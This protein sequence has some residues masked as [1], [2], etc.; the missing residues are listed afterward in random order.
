MNLIPW[1]DIPDILID[2]NYLTL[3]GSIVPDINTSFDFNM[4]FIRKFDVSNNDTNKISIF[5]SIRL[6]TKFWNINKLDS[7]DSLFETTNNN[8][9]GEQKFPFYIK[10]CNFCLTPFLINRYGNTTNDNTSFKPTN[11]Q[12]IVINPSGD[13]NTIDLVNISLTITNGYLLPEIKDKN[14]Y[15]QI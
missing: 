2:T 6:P 4:P 13:N 11:S 9:K 15:K 14:K 10:S 1:H 8:Y 5:E 7:L 3:Y 12:N